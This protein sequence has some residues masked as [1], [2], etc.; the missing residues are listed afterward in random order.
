MHSTWFSAALVL[1]ALVTA[2][3]AADK[4]PDGAA[5]AVTPAA[6]RDS[7]VLSVTPNGIGPVKAGMT[8]AVANAATGGALS[9]R[10]GADTTQ[11]HFLT[12]RGGPPHVRF[13]A[14][15]GRVARVDVDSGAVGTTEG[16]RIGDS[17]ERI[18]SLYAGRLSVQPHKYTDGHYL[19]VSP[20][21]PSDSGFRIVFETDGH[22][23]LR[24]RAGMRPQVEYVEGCA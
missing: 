19:V 17:E 4:Q 12:W 3:T 7:T 15:G 21:A 5:P 16:A 2:C 8:V 9:P 1:L 20:P 11:C 18:K 22:R 23:V 13:M 24:F 6:E 10:P 14:E